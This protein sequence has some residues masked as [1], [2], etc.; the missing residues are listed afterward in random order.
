[1]KRKR[2]FSR[3]TALGFTLI[4]VLLALSIL[5]IALSAMLKASSNT[6]FGTQKI[7][8]KTISH[9]VAMQA[10]SMI[11]LNLVKI[12]SGQSI[13][14]QENIFGQAWYWTG[15]ISSTPLYKVEKITVKVRARSGGPFIDT[16]I[17]YKTRSNE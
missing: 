12:N 3:R 9:L 11:Q 5:A 4:E 1:M 7:K 2:P 10:I 15:T 14:K 6:V 16:F 8:E 13:D 17:A